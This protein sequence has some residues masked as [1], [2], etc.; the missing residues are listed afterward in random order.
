[1]THEQRGAIQKLKW[2]ADSGTWSA[3]ITPSECVALLALIE[4]TQEEVHPDQMQIESGNLV[5][6]IRFTPV[7]NP[8]PGG[9]PAD[10]HP[11]GAL[12]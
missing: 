3:S 4:G 2:S 9:P 5:Q 12:S 11:Y 6:P 1:M 7:D 8:Q 10:V